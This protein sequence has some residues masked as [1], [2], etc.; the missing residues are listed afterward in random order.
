MKKMLFIFCL[1]LAS[2]TPVLASECTSDYEKDPSYR[3][4]LRENRFYM[5]LSGETEWQRCRWAERN[6]DDVYWR[7]GDR[8]LS[9]INNFPTMACDS[10]RLLPLTGQ[11]MTKDLK[12]SFLFYKGT[13]LYDKE[14]KCQILTNY[15][16]PHKSDYES[17]TKRNESVIPMAAVWPYEVAH[18][19]E[20]EGSNKKIDLRLISANITPVIRLEFR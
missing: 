19:Y 6:N 14:Y 1:L 4:M 10:C 11:I 9:R 15:P 18:R 3:R 8:A 12:S 5:R 13:M 2:A 16:N 20:I 7:C 17:L